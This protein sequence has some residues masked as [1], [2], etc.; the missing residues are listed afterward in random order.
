MG[1]M[2]LPSQRKVIS[3]GASPRKKKK[4]KRKKKQRKK[5]KQKKIKTLWKSSS[6]YGTSI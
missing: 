1:R 6:S 3:V 4:K 5:F 2:G